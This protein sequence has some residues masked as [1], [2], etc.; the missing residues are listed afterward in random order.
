MVWL[1]LIELIMLPAELQAHLEPTKHPF[2]YRHPVNKSCQGPLCTIP[3]PGLCATPTPQCVSHIEGETISCVP[4]MSLACACPPPLRTFYGG[5][6]QCYHKT[7]NY[8]LIPT[9]QYALFYNDKLGT[10]L[11]PSHIRAAIQWGKNMTGN[12]SCSCPNLYIWCEWE[13]WSQW[14]N[15]CTFNATKYRHRSRGCCEAGAVQQAHQSHYCATQRN[16]DPI[17][18][19]T[20][21][22]KAPT[23][24]CPMRSQFLDARKAQRTTWSEYFLLSISILLLLLII[25]TVILILKKV[26][27]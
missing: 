14:T 18:D 1:I 26:T 22:E 4:V 20:Q 2:A 19:R 7:A 17:D 12:V 27:L 21:V 8:P 6:V 16:G 9:T 13:Q 23:T 3:F 15:L 10:A 5:S 25:V 11:D 24:D